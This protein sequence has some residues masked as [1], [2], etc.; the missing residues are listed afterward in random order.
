MKK[1][2]K[3]RYFFF[4]ILAWLGFLLAGDIY[5]KI[6]IDRQ[7]VKYHEEQRD[8][9]KRHV[10]QL[11]KEIEDHNRKLKVAA[12]ELH[13]TLTNNT[14]LLSSSLLKDTLR[15]TLERHKSLYGLGLCSTTDYRFVPF[16]YREPDGKIEEGNME[17]I[18]KI[19]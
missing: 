11:T 12:L 8:I 18:K 15:N 10:S 7:N 5:Q 13:N 17:F 14:Y 6:D 9:H 1:F 4:L 3:S 2:I 19:A 16:F